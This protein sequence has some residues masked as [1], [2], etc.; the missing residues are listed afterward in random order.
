LLLTGDI[1]GTKTTLALLKNDADIRTSE[2][3]ESYPSREFDSFISILDQFLGKNPPS[4]SKAV[5]GIAGPVSDRK[6]TTTNLPWEI[7]ARGLESNFGFEQ[8]HL[9]NDLMAIASAVPH[10]EKAELKTVKQGS[11]S[12]EGAIAV[13]APG[14]GLGEAFLTWDGDHYRAHASEGGHS[15]FAPTSAIQIKLLEFMLEKKEHVSYEQVCSGIGIPH[16][17]AFLKEQNIAEEPDWLTE[18]LALARDPNPIII[19]AALDKQRVCKLC[20]ETLRI[21]AS[22]LAAESANLAL[23]LYATGGVFLAGGIPPKILPALE[24]AS[25]LRSF[26]KKG[27]M[28]TMLDQIPIHVVLNPEAALLGAAV[29]AQSG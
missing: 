19:G 1:G 13:I 23:K 6:V 29:T 22:I 16:I 3:K 25:F 14:T 21:F 2:R 8:A 20:E 7:D 26:M 15:D 27:R 5:F 18:L 24:S 10:L 17:Y 4:I 9:I 28:N 11:P 12:R